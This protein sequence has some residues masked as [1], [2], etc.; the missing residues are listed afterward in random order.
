MKTTSRTSSSQ[1]GFTIVEL[2]IV[3]SIIGIMIA[4]VLP[5]VGSAR[6]SANEANAVAGLKTLFLSQVQYRTRFGQYAV[7]LANLQ[8][9][10]FTDDFKVSGDNL[11][12]SGYEFL[13]QRVG[14]RRVVWARPID[15]GQTG[16]RYFAIGER[17]IIRHSEVGRPTEDDPAVDEK[18]V[19]AADAD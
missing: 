4:M 6:K 12:K 19:S 8:N 3:L 2:A 17:G 14:N 18:S 1:Q 7:P 9:A 16:N 10:G 13:I 15:N 5:G 11:V